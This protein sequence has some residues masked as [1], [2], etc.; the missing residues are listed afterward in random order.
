MSSGIQSPVDIYNERLQLFIKQNANF[1]QEIF[2]GTNNEEFKQFVMDYLISIAKSLIPEDQLGDPNYVEIVFFF[3]Y[4]FLFYLLINT[5]DRI[6]IEL[7]TEPNLELIKYPKTSDPRT[8]QGLLTNIT[9]NC[10]FTI[11][12]FNNEQLFVKI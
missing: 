5:R 10:I 9:T 3:V 6:S 12:D 8:E 4:S 2:K 1:N 7:L 11:I